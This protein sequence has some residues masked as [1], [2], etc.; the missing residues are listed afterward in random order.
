MYVKWIEIK[1]MLGYLAYCIV[2]LI[3]S[4]LF[5]RLVQMLMFM[6][7]FEFLQNTF[8]KRF[9]SDSI[10]ENPLEAVKWCKI[11]T[12]VIETIYL[13]YC[14]EL[15]LSLYNNLL[16]LF[17]IVFSNCL[18]Q[19]TAEK[20]VINKICLTDKNLLT[21]LC[22]EAN[23][24]SLATKR[25]IMKYIEKKTYQEIANIEFVDVESVKKSIQRSKKKLNIR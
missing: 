25:L 19:F 21:K 13:I 17:F 22:E 7:L 4:F 11:I 16:I 12:V 18:L 1:G 3:I 8:F 15:D 5:D 14:K 10:I 20:L 9:H 23:L 2:M 24:T 6:L